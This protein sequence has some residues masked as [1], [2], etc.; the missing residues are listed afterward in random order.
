MNMEMKIKG[1]VIE[2]NKPNLDKMAKAF[3]DLLE[4]IKT[5]MPS[6]S[7]FYAQK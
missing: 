6:A 3:Y 5:R 1:T 4:T 7:F 2:N